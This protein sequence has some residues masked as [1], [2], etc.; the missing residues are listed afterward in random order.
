MFRQ[1]TYIVMAFDNGG[2][3]RAGLDDIRVDGSLGEKIYFAELLRF[4][5]KHTDEFFSDNFPLP[6][7]GMDAGKTEQKSMFGID[8]DK[9]KVTPGECGLNLVRFIFAHETVVHEDAGER[10]P[11][12]FREKSCSNGGINPAGKSQQH[13]A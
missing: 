9:L 11:N 5:F 12:G 4:F 1:A 10:L 7:G 8:T 6:F 3:S 2:A 13:L